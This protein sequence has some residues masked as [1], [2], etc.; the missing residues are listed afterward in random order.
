MSKFVTRAYNK[1][2]VSSDDPYLVKES[3][4]VR[5]RDEILYYQ[6]LPESLRV[7]FPRRVEL[8]QLKAVSNATDR[9]FLAL[10]YYAYP[11]LGK[12]SLE[13]QISREQWEK[14]FKFIL[15]FAKKCSTHISASSEEDSI[16]MFVNKTER[17]HAALL[18]NPFFET[19][20]KHE[21]LYVNGKE[22][23]SF[24][25]IWPI[26]RE[27]IVKNYCGIGQWDGEFQWIHGDLCFGNI[28]YGEHENGDVI[29][30]FIDPRGSFGSTQFYGDFYYDLAKLSHSC[31]GGYEY[32]IN[33]KFFVKIDE[34]VVD[35]MYQRPDGLLHLSPTP[36][37]SD[38]FKRV[39]LEHSKFDYQKIRTL[40]GTIFVG[41]CA[42]HYDSIERQ[43]AMYVTG[44]KILN[45]VYEEILL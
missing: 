5:L 38:S 4:D 30:K 26:L 37:A 2:T 40:E 20:A 41:M 18:K 44:L 7:Y 24:S 33:D 39:I 19:L 22:I 32:F 45:E 11:D 15:N 21:T 34:N 25:K 16:D 17:E 42:R 10:E 27:H 9:H 36:E 35:L 1:I 23:L 29:L 31:N 14:V 43:K 13:K 28:L 3:T 6:H 8:E 12:A